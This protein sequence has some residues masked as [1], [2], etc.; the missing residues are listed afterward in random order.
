MWRIV[1]RDAI[2]VL[3][4]ENV[5]ASLSRYFAAIKDEKPSKFQIAKK[6]SVNFEGV[7]SIQ[8]LWQIHEQKLEEFTRLEQE[9]DN[10]QISLKELKSPKTSFFDLKQKI[11]KKILENCHF[12]TRRCNINRVRG[13]IGYCR[14]GN[15]IKVSSIFEHLGEE[16]ELIP[17]G[18]IFTLGCTICCLHCQ[19]WTISQWFESGEVYSPQQL[20]LAV[21]RLRQNGCR[22]INLVGG[23]PTPWLHQWLQTFQLVE[24]NVPIV[25]NSNTYYS[26]ETA[27]LLDGFADVF[28]L[29]FKYGNNECAEKISNAPKYWEVCTR[30]HLHAI[31]YGELI[32]RVL[33]L[34]G[35]LECCTKEILNWISGNLGKNVRVNVM[36][37]YR[38]EWRAHEIP[39]LRRRLTAEEVKRAIQL[40]KQA[41]LINYIT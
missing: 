13:E 35:H 22:N 18:T 27:K 37:Q 1:R 3:E 31:K 16:P 34:P 25:W 8:E 20:A 41:G 29:D 26:E 21:E 40:A 10:K 19:N 23:E 2:K 39:E 5:K 4:D 15:Q 6:M 28:L 12:C 24:V 17:S 7:D 33:V 9:L 30:N 38:P 14:C 32:V 11:S 36:F